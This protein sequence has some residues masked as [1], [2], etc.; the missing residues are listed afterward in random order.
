VS[1]QKGIDVNEKTEKKHTQRESERDGETAKE[2]RT[3]E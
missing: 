3:K 2:D 1:E